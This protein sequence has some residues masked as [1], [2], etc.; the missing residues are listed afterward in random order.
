M[1]LLSRLIL[2]LP[3]TITIST[4]TMTVTIILR[5]G[6]A[7]LGYIPLLRCETGANLVKIW[8][9]SLLG[10]MVLDT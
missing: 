7:F 4:I 9:G 8:Q 10:S 1:L 3:P 6:P 5:F 2:L